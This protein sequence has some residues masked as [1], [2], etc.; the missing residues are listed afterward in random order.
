MIEA[1]GQIDPAFEPEVLLSLRQQ[2]ADYSLS[3]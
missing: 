3:S 1:E 2:E